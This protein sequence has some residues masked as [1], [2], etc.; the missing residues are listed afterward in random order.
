[1]SSL[2]LSVSVPDSASEYLKN[3]DRMLIEAALRS[4]LF[5]LTSSPP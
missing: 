1:M 5:T 2:Y 4:F 3:C